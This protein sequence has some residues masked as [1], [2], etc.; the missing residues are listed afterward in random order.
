VNIPQK[1]EKFIGAPE[2]YR[3]GLN[4]EL[5]GLN[6][7]NMLQEWHNRAHSPQLTLQAKRAPYRQ[8]AG[9]AQK[10]W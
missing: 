2:V 3:S 8:T 7:R 4:Q 1:S 5:L 6:R 9:S 10:F